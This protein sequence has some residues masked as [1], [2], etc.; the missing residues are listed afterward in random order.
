MMYCL[1]GVLVCASLLGIVTLAVEAQGPPGP[2][3][4]AAGV[5]GRGRGGGGLGAG[6]NN[7]QIVDAAAA[8]RGRAVYILE[9]ITC[10]GP[11]ARGTDNGADLIQSLTVLHDRYGDTI[12]SFLQKGHAM[13]SGKSGSVLTKDQIVDLSHFIHQKV[14]ETLVRA[15]GSSPPNIV[16]GDAKAGL[17]YFNGEGKCNTCHSPTG[18]LAGFASKYDAYNVQQRFIFPFPVQGRGGRGPAVPTTAAKPVKLT[19]TPPSGPVITGELIRMDDFDISYR[20]SDGKTQN[21]A[22]VKGMKI[23]KNDPYAFHA[24]LLRTI[25]DKNM[26]DTVAYL[27]TLK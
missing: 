17:A 12:G 15:P 13:Q 24:A 6:P 9:C 3:A 1:R 5:S 25:T 27:E 14:N 19:I 22:R 11:K 26:H 7:K 18:D 2:P 10:H 20:D 8:D 23:E 16:T 4:G 21:I